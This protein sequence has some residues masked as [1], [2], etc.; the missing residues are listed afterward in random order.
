MKQLGLVACLSVA[1]SVDAQE[2]DTFC[3]QVADAAR[4]SYQIEQ[5]C[6][7]QEA[8]AMRKLDALSPPSRIEDF[9]SSVAQTAGGSY[10]I[11][12]M[13]VQRELKAKA[14]LSSA[15]T[16]GSATLYSSL[17]RNFVDAVKRDDKERLSSLVQYP[18]RRA[19]PLV[20][21]H[22]ATEFK[23]RF[24]AI[25]GEDLKQ[26]IVNSDVLQDWQRIGNRGIVF[27]DGVLW[28]TPDGKLR[29]INYEAESEEQ[30]REALIKAEKSTLHHSLRQYSEPVLEWLTNEYRIRIDRSSSGEFRYAAWSRNQSTM[31]QP[32][33]ILTNGVMIPDGSGGNHH[34]TF[35]RDDYEYTC[36]V[37]FMGGVPAGWLIVKKLGKTLLRQPVVEEVEP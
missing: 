37:N 19:Y 10:Q 21:V 14:S 32:N 20:S 18:L 7:E 22:T 35:T 31:E 11:M 8:E 33:L 12:L 13:C 5:T 36:R 9:C 26:K 3:R 15:E 28:L 6:R 1:T 17:I 23:Q 4:D 16:S 29:S 30:Q 2:I 24:D 34:Y 25:F 27:M